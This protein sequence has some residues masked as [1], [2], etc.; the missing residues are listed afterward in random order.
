MNVLGVSFL[1][2]FFAEQE[3][4]VIELSLWSPN[5]TLGKVDCCDDEI[6]LVLNRGKHTTDPLYINYDNIISKDYQSSC[7]FLDD[8]L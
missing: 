8:I 7:I 5:Q 1:F 2:V 4:E 3:L 6:E